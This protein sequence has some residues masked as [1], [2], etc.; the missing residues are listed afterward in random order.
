MEREP[1]SLLL[2]LVLLMLQ[3]QVAARLQPRGA[4]EAGCQIAANLAARELVARSGQPS[5]SGSG[6]GSVSRLEAFAVAGLNDMLVLA[7]FDRAQSV[8]DGRSCYCF[9]C[10][11]T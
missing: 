3:S 6:C 10:S 1:L 4:V 2:L 8:A 11:L 5:Q 7:V 9:G